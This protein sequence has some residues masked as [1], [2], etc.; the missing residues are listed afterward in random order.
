MKEKAHRF[1]WLVEFQ[2]CGRR[3]LTKSMKIYLKETG[4]IGE[5][6]VKQ[7][8]MLFVDHMNAVLQNQLIVNNI[9]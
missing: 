4:V 9:N 6:R 7:V 2:R 8:T 3:Q 1:L 5:V